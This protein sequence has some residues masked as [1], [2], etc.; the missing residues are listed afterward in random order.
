MPI[1][2][3]LAVILIVLAL[4]AIGF[5][6]VFRGRTVFSHER[7]QENDFSNPIYQDRD[8]EP[9][10][11]DADKSGNFVNPVYDSVYN[12]TTSGREEKAVLLD[13]TTDETPP[14]PTEEL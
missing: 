6:Y 3:A 11:L 5:Q 12:G 1:G 9:F 2:Y 10:T 8:A 14:P 7:L 4:G 13:H